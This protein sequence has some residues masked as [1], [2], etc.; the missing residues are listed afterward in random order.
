MAVVGDAN[1]HLEGRFVIPGGRTVSIGGKKVIVIGDVAEP[2]MAGHIPGPTNASTGL[3]T[4][5]IGQ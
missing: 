2:D 4:I 1:D 5:T 3:G